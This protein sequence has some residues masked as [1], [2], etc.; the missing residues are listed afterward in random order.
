MIKDAQEIGKKFRESLSY[1]NSPL[2]KL[3]PEKR[4]LI[5]RSKLGAP[6]STPT[7]GL[8]NVGDPRP[9]PHHCHGIGEER[10]HM[11]HE[12]MAKGYSREDVEKVLRTLTDKSKKIKTVKIEF[13]FDK[14]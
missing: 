5:V 3:G 11:M 7:V 10:G 1:K 13:E 8:P 4:G 6:L 9:Q 2:G 14:E 12:L